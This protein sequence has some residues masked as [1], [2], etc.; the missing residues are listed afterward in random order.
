MSSRPA[1]DDVPV[2]G[3]DA[4][5]GVSELV[6]SALTGYAMAPV[7]QAIATKAGEDVYAKIRHLLGGHHDARPVPGKPITLVDPGARTVLQIPEKLDRKETYSLRAVRMP[8]ASREEWLLIRYDSASKKWVA[9]RVTEPPADAI[10]LGDR[11]R[12]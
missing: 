12:D 8:Q 1:D 9:E 11:S 4:E 6:V 5:R 7:V 2:T 3:T 10:E